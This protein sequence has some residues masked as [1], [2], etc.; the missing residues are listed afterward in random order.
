MIKEL[1]AQNFITGESQTNEIADR[2]FSPDSY[3]INLFKA[4]GAL[5]FIEAATDRGGATLTGNIIASAFDKSYLG[6]DAYFLDDEGAF[7]TLSGAT[8]TKR[9]TAIADTFLLGTSDLLNFLGNTYA[10]SLTRVMELTSSNLATIDSGWWTGLTTAYRHP[11]ERVESEMFIGDVNNIH[12]W[13]GTS[14][15][16]NAIVLPTD[17]NIT[18]LRKHPDGRTLL[19]FCGLTANYSH[20]QG[21]AGRVYFIDPTL[22]DWTREVELDTQVEGSCVSGGVVFVTYSKNLGYF[23]GNGIRFL[24]KLQTS[25]TTYS[26]N[27]KNMEDKLIFRDGRYVIAYGNFGG[28]NAFV[29]IF[30]TTNTQNV[31]NIAYKGDGVFL[32]AHS[33]GAG[34]GFLKEVD[35]D[36][37][38]VA[39]VFL[40][41]PIS[42]GQEVKIRRLDLIHDVTSAGVTR[43]QFSFEDPDGN[44]NLIEDRTYATATSKTRIPCDIT[45]D[46]FKLKVDPLAGTVGIK[47]IR[48]HYDP[49]K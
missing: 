13:N 1:N 45:T 12:I 43:F 21:A 49:I 5:Y 39:G 41:N 33:D 37:A 35:L 46:L 23:D 24:K 26:H 40:T 28:G 16:A 17:V 47:L 8:F 14:S 4:L 29:K 20:T 3:G 11:L 48:I 7:Y 30:R 25:G 22:R 38:G 42:F 10:T 36:N 32:A 44:S 31:N 18:S 15:T 34:A 19:A 27:L 2:G 6:N 9:Q